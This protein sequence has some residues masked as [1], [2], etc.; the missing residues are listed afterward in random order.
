MTTKLRHDR[1]EAAIY[2]KRSVESI[3]GRPVPELG[4][5]VVADY[6]GDVRIDAERFGRSDAPPTGARGFFEEQGAYVT[7]YRAPDPGEPLALAVFA[8]FVVLELRPDG[9]QSEFLV[10]TPPRPESLQGAAYL[11]LMRTQNT[12]AL[13]AALDARPDLST[14]FADLRE[15]IAWLRDEASRPED[16]RTGLFARWLGKRPR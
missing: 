6:V 11:G 1:L 10:L 16:R 13:V 14:L 3:V 15:L 8:T 7:A 4:P 5:Y 12:D 2:G 9:P